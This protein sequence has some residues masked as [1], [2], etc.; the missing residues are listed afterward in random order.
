MA[1]ITASIETEYIVATHKI[2]PFIA[3]LALITITHE[4]GF[5]FSIG[6]LILIGDT[7]TA[8]TDFENGYKLD[9]LNTIWIFI[10]I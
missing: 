5:I 9:I 3:T 10:I 6:M 7:A 8:L 2:T 1:S 4:P